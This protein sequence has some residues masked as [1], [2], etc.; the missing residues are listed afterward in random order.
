M[1]NRYQVSNDFKQECKNDVSVNR[2]GKI[3]IVEDNIDITEN[4]Y[5]VDF[6]IEDS[7]YVNDA[8]IGTTVSKKITVNILNPNNELDLTNKEITVSVGININGTIEYVPLGNYI[9]EEPS[10]KEVEQTSSFVGYDYMSKFNQVYEDNMTYPITL[11]QYLQSICT[12]LGIIL[13]STSLINENYMITGNP[14]T[15]GEDYRTVLSNVAQLCGGFAHI[16]RDNKLYIVNLGKTAVETIDGNYYM[17]DFEN[18]NMYGEVNS[19]VIGLENVDG[20]NTYRQDTA[21]IE[22]NGLTEIQINNN[23]F[24]NSAEEREKV[25]DAIWNEVKGLSYLAFKTTY[26]GFPYLDIGDKIN[27]VDTK[28]TSHVSYILNHKF[29]Y[30]GSFS[31]TL[32]VTALTKTQEAYKNVVTLSQWKRNTEYRVD[33]INGQIESIVSEQSQFEEKLAQQE[34]EVD[35]I[36][37]QV[38]DTVEYKREAEGITEVYIEDAGK[39]DILELEIQGNKTYENYLYP[40]SENLYP[41]GSLYPNIPI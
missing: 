14:F 12:Q 36:K 5:I 6:T 22:L 19:L 18:N 3:H 9:I 35:S 4:D 39:A 30:N 13:G 15:N 29:I 40:L 10:N 16:G 24:L 21:S 1:T 41:S 2:Y 37:Q 8:F 31:G 27:I 11:K 25:I 32:E 28:D 7:C 33:K 23:Y 20:E 34:I 17:E 38:S 26:Y